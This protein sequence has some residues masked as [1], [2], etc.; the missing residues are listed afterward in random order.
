MTGVIPA[1]LDLP[2]GL[3]QTR[4]GGMGMRVL[5]VVCVQAV[6]LGAPGLAATPAG[7]GDE[8]TNRTLYER[9]CARCHGASGEGNG[10]F[11]SSSG[12]RPPGLT[13]L[14][15]AWGSP[16]P[17]ASLLHHVVDPRRPGG[18]RICGGRDRWWA[19]RGSAVALHRRGTVLVVLDYLE[20]M[21][22]QD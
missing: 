5:A 22:R 8:S 9:H 12:Q 18:A 1:R 7:A 6:L 15:S 16:L 10:P 17:K 13:H 4:V 3:V 20:T 21:Q 14:A 2:E 19:E 11:S